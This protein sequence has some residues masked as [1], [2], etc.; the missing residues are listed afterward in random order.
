MFLLFGF[1]ILEAYSCGH[2]I[3][4]DVVGI[5]GNLKTTK[6]HLVMDNHIV[7]GGN[8]GKEFDEIMKVLRYLESEL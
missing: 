7:H 3:N 1:K 5:L 6:S 8:S 2:C 4:L